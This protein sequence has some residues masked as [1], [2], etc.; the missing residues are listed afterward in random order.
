M[1]VV[2]S[3][4][5]TFLSVTFFM[6]V[7]YL[8]KDGLRRKSNKWMLCALS[9]MYGCAAV[10]YAFQLLILDKSFKATTTNFT[11]RYDSGS[12]VAAVA[13]SGQYIIQGINVACGDL[14]ILWRTGMVWQDNATMR[15]LNSLFLVLIIL[16]WIAGIAIL[17]VFG[18][19][20]LL[21]PL[22][23]SLSVNLWS[24]AA[25]GY[26]TWLRRRMLRQ[27]VFMAGRSSASAVEGALTVITET[28]VDYTTIW[29][30]YVAFVAYYFFGSAAWPDKAALYRGFQ[31]SWMIMSMLIPLYPTLLILL[32]ARHKTPLTETLTSIDVDTAV[33]TTSTSSIAGIAPL[34]T[35]VDAD[36]KIGDDYYYPYADITASTPGTSSSSFPLTPNR[37]G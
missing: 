24:T 28:G 30:V 29:I 31:W 13:S 4:L 32:I 36:E 2:M 20:F 35:V 34:Q 5:F 7:R 27:R 25:I 33:P 22:A 26:K 6:A 17:S 8:L 18:I 15:R 1:S 9:V 3:I 11:G 23:L 37:R 10:S 12:I 19:Q 16:T 21:I 14:V